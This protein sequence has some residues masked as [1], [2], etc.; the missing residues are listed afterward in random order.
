MTP[1]T[2]NSPAEAQNTPI[3][4]V[5]RNANALSAW[6]ALAPDPRSNLARVFEGRIRFYRVIGTFM[7][8]EGKF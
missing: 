8:A 1:Q 2:A 3:A 5:Q 4:S 6:S 7:R